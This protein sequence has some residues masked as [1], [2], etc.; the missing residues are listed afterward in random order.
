VKRLVEVKKYDIERSIMETEFK[1]PQTLSNTLSDYIRFPAPEECLKA[2]KHLFEMEA[3]LERDILLMYLI[4]N[5]VESGEVIKIQELVKR[6]RQ[7]YQKVLKR[8]G[9]T[10]KVTSK[11]AFLN[12]YINLCL[13]DI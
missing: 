5:V 10:V 6:L 12:G 8:H 4:I 3:D 11:L 13:N 9:L 7:H 2:E 1:A